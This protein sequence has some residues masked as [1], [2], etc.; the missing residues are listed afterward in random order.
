MPAL[1]TLAGGARGVR[2]R[3][4]KVRDVTQ[5]DRVA[6]LYDDPFGPPDVRES[7]APDGG[8]AV[9]PTGG[10]PPTVATHLV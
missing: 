1:L 8:G 2:W 10:G 7:D 6:A 3:E 9:A 5:V 4:D